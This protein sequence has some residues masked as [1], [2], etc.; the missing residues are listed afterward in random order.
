M[1]AEIANLPIAL[2]D[3]IVLGIMLI[4]VIVGLCTGFVRSVVKIL[5]GILS[6]VLAFVLCKTLANVLASTFGL[7][8][9]LTTLFTGWLNV[10]PSVSG[11]DAITAQLQS[12]NLPQYI[13]D[14]I[15]NALQSAG[16]SAATTFNETV[17]PLLAKIALVVGS[18]II[19]WILFKII[20]LIIKGMLK[21]VD[22]IPIIRGINK[23]LGAVFGFLKGA[24]LILTALMLVS[25]FASAMPTA[26][27][28]EIDKS[29]VTK[30][31]Y[32]NNIEGEIISGLLKDSKYL[33]FLTDSSSDKTS[34]QTSE[35]PSDQTSED[36]SNSEDT[37]NSVG[38]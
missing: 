26:V 4:F 8:E 30:Y 20:F 2:A 14:L 6:L 7:D 17:P 33:K 18:F 35:Q 13:T 24:V 22:K 3:C 5:S 16:V 9:K 23:L 31:C 29:T 27:M 19:L 12:M 21:F 28:D 34:D 36:R 25:V 15:V 37:S 1:V 10:D 38:E 11:V 32:E